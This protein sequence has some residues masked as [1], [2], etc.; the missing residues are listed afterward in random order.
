MAP[1]Y[2]DRD[3]LGFRVPLIMLSPY[4]RHNHVSHVHYEFGSILRFIEDR[5][6]VPSLSA[7]DKRATSPA[8]DCFDFNQPPRK[9]AIIQAKR[10]ESYFIHQ[11]LDLRPVDD[12]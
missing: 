3:S 6:D 11:P 5:D 1:E 8:A 2:K 4:V 9:F 7:S 12:E 10:D